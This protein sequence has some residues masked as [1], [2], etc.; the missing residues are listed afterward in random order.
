MVLTWGPP[1]EAALEETSEI[2]LSKT[3]KYWQK[4]IKSANISNFYQR[5]AIR[6]ALILKIHQYE[7]TGA[8]VAATTTSF[9]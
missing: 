4:W 1:L 3:T 8:I 2:F 9:A 7:D 5:E 6:S